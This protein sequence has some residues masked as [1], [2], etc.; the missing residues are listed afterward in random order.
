MKTKTPSTGLLLTI[1][2]SGL[3]FFPAC[4]KH[5]DASGSAGRVQFVAIA[6]Q[7]DAAA[8]QTFDDVFNNTM[9]VSNEVAIGGTG[10]FG[11]TDVSTGSSNRLEGVDSTTCYTLITKQ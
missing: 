1:L 3:L 5:D 6:A 11:R 4:K 8:E 7:S 10:V 2:A 9:G